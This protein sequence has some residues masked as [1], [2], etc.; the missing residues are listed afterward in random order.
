MRYSKY[1]FWAAW[2][3]LLLLILFNSCITREKCLE[4]F[5]PQSFD[6]VSTDRE[7][8]NC[9]DTVYYPGNFVE[10]GDDIPCPELEYHKTETKKWLT[11]KVDISKGKIV[12]TCK[13]D[14]LIRIIEKQKETI[15]T[16]KS[17]VVVMPP[18]IVK[19]TPLIGRACEWF[20]GILLFILLVVLGYKYVKNKLG[21]RK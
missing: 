4:R 20:T 7:L 11:V 19:E 14:S 8:T 13:E 1:N 17:R 21:V 6:S 10:I 3:F 9:V 2:L 12:T 18:Q 16:N 5:P 15:R